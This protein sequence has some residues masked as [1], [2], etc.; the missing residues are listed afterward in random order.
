MAEYV[1][2]DADPKVNPPISSCAAGEIRAV[3]GEITMEQAL[4]S[5]DTLPM[6]LVPAG[7][8]PVDAIVDTDSLDSGS[9]IVFDVGDVDANGDELVSGSTIGQGGGMARMAQQGGSRLAPY[10][11]QNRRMGLTVTTGPGSAVTPA[12]ITV[13]VFYRRSHRGS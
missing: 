3:Q 7:H 2:R 10:T 5:G 9:G 4:A 8:V 11:D 6:A 13:T 12:T 1:A